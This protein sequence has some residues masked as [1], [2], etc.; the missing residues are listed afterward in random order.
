MEK[1]DGHSIAFPGQV[2]ARRWRLCRRGLGCRLWACGGHDWGEEG[3]EG[4]VG[5]LGGRSSAGGGGEE[6]WKEREGS[7]GQIRGQLA[8]NPVS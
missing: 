8:P 1:G 6:G 7:A 2:C 4:I 5:A 3:A